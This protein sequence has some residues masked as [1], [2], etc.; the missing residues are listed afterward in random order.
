M[1]RSGIALLAVAALS[2]SAHAADL[3]SNTS[4]PSAPMFSST[5]ASSWGG[6]YAGVSG[7]Y[8]WGTTSNSPEFAG[9]DVDNNSSGWTV[10]GQAGYNMDLGGFVIGGEADLQ[11]ANI[12]YSDDAPGGGDFDADI[13]VFGTLRA[14]VGVPVGQVMPYGTFGV[15]YGR[16]SA[17]V[18]DGVTTTQT[19]NHFGWTAG[20]GIEAQ[21]TANLSIKAEYLYLDLGEQA[22]DGL[23][24]SVGDRDIGQRFSVIRVGANYK[25]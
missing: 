20:V 9:G 24:A 25:F 22:Y 13:D 11:W 5:T 4:A 16:G 8:G 15:A 3:W 23:P 12:G 14:R 7:G 19:A 2:T 18:D 10:G 21:A 1:K 6:F 17:T